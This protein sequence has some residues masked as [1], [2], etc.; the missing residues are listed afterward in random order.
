ME[1]GGQ[2]HVPA[3][4]PPAKTRYPLYR[5]L[6]RPQGRSGRVRRISPPPRFDPRTF[7][8]ITQSLYRL[9]YPSVSTCSTHENEVHALKTCASLHA[10]RLASGTIIGGFRMDVELRA[11]VTGPGSYFVHHTAI[12]NGNTNWVMRLV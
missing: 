9:C 10:T 3:I 11:V 1:V 12:T 6:V 7:Q 5:R 8:P 2:R 4:L